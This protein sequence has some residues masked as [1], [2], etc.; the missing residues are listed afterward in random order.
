M[1]VDKKRTAI[2]LLLIVA[3]VVVLVIMF[4]PV[5]G[6]KNSL[7]YLDDLYNSISKGS[8]YYIPIVK[9]ESDAFISHPV[10]VTLKM[11]STEE[12]R[13]T[14]LLYQG[15]EAE[16]VASKA[17]LKITGDLGRILESCLN[18][19]DIMYNN[20]GSKIEEK[21][22]YDA[23]L[24]LLNWWKS[25]KMM[26]KELSKQKMFREAK[27]V[28]LVN[29]KAVETSYNYYGVEPQ[30]ITDRFGVVTV[31]LVFYVVYTLWYGFAIMYLFE[32]GGLKL[33]H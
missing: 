18:D 32:G 10:S 9:E 5:F 23:R 4:M 16:A 29:K 6:G 7:E 11:D 8:A 21:Y 14:A 17:E 24:V 20:S 15:G 33:S 28:S 13:Q 1:S 12:A 2:G 22:G 26:D 27:V 25:L 19:A 3:F 30:K 31:S